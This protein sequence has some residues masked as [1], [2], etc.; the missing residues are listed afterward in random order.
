MGHCFLKLGNPDKARLAFER[1]LELDPKCVGA[2]VGLAIL[3][4]NLQEADS[5]R[6]GVQLL[7]RAYTVDSSN[8]MVLNHLAN[9]FFFKMVILAICLCKTHNNSQFLC[10]ITRKFSIWRFTLFT[11]LK[12]K[13]CEQNR[14]TNWHELSMSKAITIKLFNTITRLEFH[15]FSQTFYRLIYKF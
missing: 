11:I 6:N 3:E 12:T 2:L 13:L 15:F 14:V 9:H 1:A 4:L 7:S 8:P 10:R 5:I